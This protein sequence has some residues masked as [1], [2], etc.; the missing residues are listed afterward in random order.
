M[1]WSSIFNRNLLTPYCIIISGIGELCSIIALYPAL[2]PHII[3]QENSIWIQQTGY[4]FYAL[5]LI[6]IILISY[7]LYKFYKQR[8][9]C[10]NFLSKHNKLLANLFSILFKVLG[11]KKYLRYVGPIS[12]SYGILYALISGMI[13]YRPGQDLS[14][15]YGVSI[16]SISITSYG[17]VGFVPTTS[18]Y[19]TENFGILVIPVNLLVILL[20]SIL[21]GLNGT[22]SLYAFRDRKI[23]TTAFSNNA[24]YSR[25][26]NS[27]V[28]ALSATVGLFAACPSCASLY[29]F[30]ILSGSLAP[31][32]AAFTVTF[33][34]F[35]IIVSIPLLILT[36]FMTAFSIHKRQVK[37]QLCQL[38]K[39]S[40]SSRLK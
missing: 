26:A 17:P 24:L 22:M 35:S 12:I 6:G 2:L 11:N 28:G 40:G 8:S 7:G 33:Y 18:I 25:T 27:T 32:V 3:T 14:S 1:S 21:V 9:F 29:I 30:T 19:I 16:P 37:S 23:N 36:L 13:I 4:I 15:L 10:I 5:L 39:K 34:A 20:V 38:D 31:T